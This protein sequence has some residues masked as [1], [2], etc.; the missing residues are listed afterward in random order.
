MAFY[1]NKAVK[2]PFFYSVNMSIN[3]DGFSNPILA[4]D[5]VI[6]IAAKHPLVV[7]ANTLPWEQML[8]LVLPDLQRTEH[9]CW[10]VGRPLRVRIHLGIYL[11]QQWFD[12]TDRQ[13]EYALHDNAAFQL[14]CGYGLMKHWHVPD[15]T[16]IEE[17]RSR[18]LTETQRQLAN[19]IGSSPHF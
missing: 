6:A 17:F 18:L 4:R 5:V 13:A 10:W 15:H 11:L 9:C 3:I 1:Y 7:L 12:L 8:A 14:F 16:K 19:S 2:P